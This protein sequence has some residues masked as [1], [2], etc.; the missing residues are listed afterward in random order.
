VLFDAR[1]YFTRESEEMLRY[2]L[3][4]VPRNRAILQKY[5][6]RCAALFTVSQG[7]ADEYWREFGVAM[8]VVR[9]TPRFVRAAAQR[10][11]A[12]AV[13]MVHHGI[14][15]Q[16]RRID[17]MI[18]VVRLLDERFTLDLYLVGSEAQLDS[19]RE[20][21]AGCERVKILQPVAFAEIVPMLN[22]YDVGFYYLEPTGFNVTYNVPNKIFEFIQARLALA[23]GPSPEMANI[24]NHFGCGVVAAEFS[25][26]SMVASLRNLTEVDIDRMKLRSDEAASELC[27]ERESLKVEAALARL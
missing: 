5:L 4:Y 26:E 23:V 8:T 15:S 21:A 18:E 2:R 12:G 11:H 20:A 10:T 1:E 3:L 25:V 22:R 14:A 24:V 7:L 6:K 19:L 13:R 9:S 27:W 16:D 17:R